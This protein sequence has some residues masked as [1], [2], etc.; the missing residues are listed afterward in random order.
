MATSEQTVKIA[1]KLYQTRS[2]AKVMLGARYTE[3]TAGMAD[4]IRDIIK[5]SPRKNL[6]PLVVAQEMAHAPGV[7]TAQV[8]MVLATAVDMI[9]GVI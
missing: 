2:A 7:D 6:S 4:I 9:D 8:I 5:E 3:F 1:D